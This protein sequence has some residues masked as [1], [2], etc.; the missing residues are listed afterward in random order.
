M[1]QKLDVEQQRL[2]L[3]FDKSTF[4]KKLEREMKH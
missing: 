2:N 1:K 3:E 4:V